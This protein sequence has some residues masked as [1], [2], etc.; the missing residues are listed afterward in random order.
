MATLQIPTHRCQDKGF[1]LH[2]YCNEDSMI[3][4]QLSDSFFKLLLLSFLLFTSLSPLFPLFPPAL[5]PE[6]HIVDVA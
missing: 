5:S 3:F 1:T 4:S 2:V 6:V